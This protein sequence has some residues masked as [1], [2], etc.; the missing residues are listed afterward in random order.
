MDIGRTEGTDDEIKEAIGRKLGLLFPAIS[1]VISDAHS[2][3]ELL[4][5]H[6][7]DVLH[8]KQLFFILDNIDTVLAAQKRNVMGDVLEALISLG[9]QVQ[10]L[11]TSRDKSLYTN[12]SLLEFTELKPIS[13]FDCREW[14]VSENSRAN[15]K[16]DLIVAISENCGGVPLV[17]KIM[18]SKARRQKDLLADELDS[19]KTSNDWNRLT[20]SLQL[21]FNLLTSDQVDLLQCASIFTVSFTKDSLMHM[22][23]KMSDHRGSGADCLAILF[24]LSL[25]EYDSTASTYYLHPYIQEY[26]HGTIGDGRDLK[27]L[28]ALFVIT[29]FEKMLKIADE[30]IQKDNF[31]RVLN[32]I[33]QD[34]H[35]YEKFMNMLSRDDSQQIDALDVVLKNNSGFSC[36]WMLTAFWFLNKISRFKKYITLVAE[37]LEIM[38]KKLGLKAH[39][40]LCKCFVAHQLR[41]VSGLGNVAKARFKINEAKI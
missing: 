40:I 1:T 6:A 32:D 28:N 30:Q 26:V 3:F 23:S 13:S 11:T 21:S 10:V 16:D 2:P 4:I 19:I 17:L 35:N 33:V 22:F 8:Q 34:S 27:H 5:T 25:T 37:E 9:N 38:F 31:A 39:K 24:D 29:Y 12:I 14:M 36:F 18:H 20:Q 15:I 41:L 7:R